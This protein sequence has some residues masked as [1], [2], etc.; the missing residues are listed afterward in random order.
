ME[1]IFNNTII[2]VITFV[3]V[4]NTLFSLMLIIYAL[5]AKYSGLAIP[6]S[7]GLIIIVAL[8]SG[9]ILMTIGI[10]GV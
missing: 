3:F 1:K 4:T 9:I 7:S 2:F 10:T 6:G 5:Y 8:F